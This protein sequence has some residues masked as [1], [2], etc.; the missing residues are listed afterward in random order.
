MESKIIKRVEKI[1]STDYC[2]LSAKK[3][4]KTDIVFEERISLKCLICKKYNQKWTCP[5][6]IPNLDYQKA[7]LEYDYRLLVYN[8]VEFN[9]N[10][11]TEVRKESSRQL[12]KNLLSLEAFL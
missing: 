7:I 8:R 4:K 11:F 12:H 6:K 2:N 10:I 9:K 5:P 1:A 3:I